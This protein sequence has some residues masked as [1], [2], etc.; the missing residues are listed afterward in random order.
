MLAV[1]AVSGVT[2]AMADVTEALQAE[3]ADNVEVSGIIQTAFYW[4][5]QLH[6]SWT[7]RAFGSSASALLTSLVYVQHL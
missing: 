2:T 1:P 4:L 3:A 5:T 6:S 7:N